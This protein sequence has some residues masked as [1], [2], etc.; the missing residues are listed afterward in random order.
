MEV[1]EAVE[2]EGNL[3][4]LTSANNPFL[5]PEMYEPLALHLNHSMVI[6]QRQMNL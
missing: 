2:E 4:T 3:L 6:D 1:V 5:K